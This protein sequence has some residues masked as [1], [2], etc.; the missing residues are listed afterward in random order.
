MTTL[1]WHHDHRQITSERRA[2]SS[3]EL[4]WRAHLAEAYE[5]LTASDEY[6]HAR[7]IVRCQMA[8]RGYCE[9]PDNQKGTT[10]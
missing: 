6:E 4:V 7:Y 10:Q 2:M 3:D 5:R 8:R 9:H 1:D